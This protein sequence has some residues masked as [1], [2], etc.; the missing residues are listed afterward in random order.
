[1]VIRKGTSPQQARSIETRY[2]LLDAAIECIYAVG[3]ARTTSM[4]IVRRSGVSRG[5]YLHLFGSKESL[6]VQALEHLITEHCTKI[7]SLIKRAKSENITE[8]LFDLLKQ[9]VYGKMALVQIE[10]DLAGRTDPHLGNACR[11]LG[12]LVRD[13][14]NRL[15]ISVYGAEAVER[16][17]IRA[18]LEM[19]LHLLRGILIVEVNFPERV[20]EQV[21]A[22]YRGI[23]ASIVD[24]EINEPTPDVPSLHIFSTTSNQKNT[25]K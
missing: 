11:E 18:R 20:N 23:I 17:N 8:T 12:Q 14:M 10:L 2:K 6:V 16:A 19:G 7:E 25:L 9:N 5:S 21:W 24:T 4:E 1:M 22:F 3:Y 13:S 15:F